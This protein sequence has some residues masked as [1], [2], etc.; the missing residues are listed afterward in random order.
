[1]TDVDIEN[2]L[3]E[4]NKFINLVLAEYGYKLMQNKKKK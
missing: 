4:N 1:M 2:L 3:K